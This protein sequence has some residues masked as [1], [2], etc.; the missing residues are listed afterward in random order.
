MKNEVINISG[1]ECYEKDGT[2]YLKLDTVARGLGFT[3]IAESGNEVVRWERVEKYL[4][5]LGVPT[6]GHDDFIPENI[7]YRLA[8]SLCRLEINFVPHK[9]CGRCAYNKTSAEKETFLS[10]VG[11]TK[12]ERK[13]CSTGSQLSESAKKNRF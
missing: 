7:F 9:F 5:D 8:I 3:R 6:C 4:N 13:E 11:K 1:V 12:Y 10:S 2:A